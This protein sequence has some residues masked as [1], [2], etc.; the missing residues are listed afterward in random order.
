MSNYGNSR[1]GYGAKSGSPGR[2]VNNRIGYVGNKS[3][4][5]SSNMSPKPAAAQPNIEIIENRL[6]FVSSSRPPQSYQD[7]YFFS[8]D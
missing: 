3:M 6:Y 2:A 8:V 4:K 1:Y 7:A 5:K